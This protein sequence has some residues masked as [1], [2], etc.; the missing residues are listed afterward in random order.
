MKICWDNLEKLKYSRKRNKWY[1]V[2]PKGGYEYYKYIDNCG[3]CNNPFLGSE[4]KKSKFCSNE[5]FSKN[6]RGK[7]YRKKLSIIASK[8]IGKLNSNYQ[9]NWTETQKKA[10]SVRLKGN[11]LGDKR[12]DH[13]LKMLGSKNPN[14]QG[15]ISFEPY[16]EIWKDSEYKITIKERD[17][18]ECKNSLCNGNSNKLCIHH[19]DYN[20]KNCH[21]KNL[22][23][24]CFSC[25]ARANFNRKFWEM[26]YKKIKGE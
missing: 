8:R 4:K 24:I 3:Y 17:N 16:C 10:A 14:W 11:G 15:G 9:N 25:N 23:T 26:F 19:I 22:I 18:Y 20:K 6:P 5:C 12:P 2:Y 13:S 7:E 1:R 21:P